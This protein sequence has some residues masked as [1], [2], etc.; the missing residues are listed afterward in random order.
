MHNM[1]TIEAK[2]REN[3]RKTAEETLFS[4]VPLAKYLHL[5]EAAE[6]L[7]HSSLI[8]NP[9]VLPCKGFHTGYSQQGRRAALR[10]LEKICLR[11]FTLGLRSVV[12]IAWR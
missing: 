10:L 9:T 12:T 8:S 5:D 6:A 1:R 11:L 3:Q 7:R 4:F 2:P